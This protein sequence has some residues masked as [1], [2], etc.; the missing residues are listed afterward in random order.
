MTSPKKD[1]LDALDAQTEVNNKVYTEAYY[2]YEAELEQ[3]RRATGKTDE[4]LAGEDRARVDA[5]TAK[6]LAENPDFSDF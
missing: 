1:I 4:E 6:W 5:E 2:E 3:E